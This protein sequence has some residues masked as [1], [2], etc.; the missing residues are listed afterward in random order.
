MDTGPVLARREE[1]IRSDDDAGSLGAR[2]AKIGADAVAE[3]LP[4]LAD[5]IRDADDRRPATPRGHPSSGPPTGSIDWAR[6]RGRRRPPR[7]RV[8]ARPG[9]DTDVPGRPTSSCSAPRRWTARRGDARRDRR[10][11]RPRTASSSRRG[12]GAV[13]LLEVAASGRR[14]MPA[15]DWA[16][17][18]RDLAGERLGR[19]RGTARS[20]ASRPSAASPTRRRTPRASCPR[21]LERSRLDARDRALATELALGTLRHLPALDRAIG[22][23]ASRPL[24]RMSPGARAALRLGAYQLLFMRIP[25]HAAVSASVDLAT[26]RE[27]GF[28][29]AILRQLADDPPPRRRR[30]ST[31]EAIFAA[32]RTGAVGVQRAP[33]CSSGA[34]EAEVAAEAFGERGLAQPPHEHRAVTSVDAFVRGLRASGHTPRT[35]P[36]ASGLRA[37]GRRATRRGCAA[38]RRAGSPCRIR[39]PRSSFARSTRNRATGCSTSARL[40]AARRRTSRVWSARRDASS[41]A[42]V[43]PERAALVRSDRGAPRRARA[44]RGAGR[45]S[46]SAR[47][48]VR[49]GAGGRAVLGH[50]VGAP[51]TRS[52]SGGRGGLSSRRWRGSR[53]PSRPRRPIGSVPVAASS[54][55]CA[56]SR[57]RRRMRRATRLRQ[58][59]TRTGAR[60]DRWSGRP[61]AARAVCGRTGTAPTA[62]SSR[63]SAS[64]PDRAGTIA[65]MG[66]LSASILSADFAHLADQVK[67]VE[68]YAEVI[69]IDVMDAHF[70]PP[71][72]IGPVVVAS[73]RPVT[74]RVFHGHL[75]VEAPEGLFDDLARGRARHRLVPSSK[76][77]R[78][79][80]RSIAKARGAGHARGHDASTWRRRS[81][82]SSRTSTSWTT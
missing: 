28:V 63:P 26:P 24:A 60:A 46:S 23:R 73:L 33:R 38:S 71:L 70:V 2:L 15:A 77:S 79:L 5:G 22:L 21:S 20:V 55:R 6:A 27:R 8:R 48:V 80:R 49:P 3:V 36:A 81:T 11:R 42:D 54:T 64:G 34:D 68:P 35:A 76:R 69:H 53:W 51:A 44:R 29:N 13:R 67:L 41:P 43:R 14:R 31:D 75:M 58:A 45:H 39:R 9:R 66:M 17:G 1:A 59:S 65:P 10:R 57:A 12:D 32:D 72:T 37:P 25:S 40:R 18:A 52:C 50:R 7:P 82:R 16:R 19:D 30:A 78:T 4:T 61:L 62:C 74:E 47:R 56:R